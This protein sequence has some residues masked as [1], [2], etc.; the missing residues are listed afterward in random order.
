[1]RGILSIDNC[2]A[3]YASIKVQYDVN[4]VIAEIDRLAYPSSEVIKKMFFHA[5]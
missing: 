5:I 3:K 2:E 4:K 1:M